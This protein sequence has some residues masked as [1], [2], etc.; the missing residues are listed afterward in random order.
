MNN[1]Y[2]SNIPIFGVSKFSNSD[3]LLTFSA[4]GLVILNRIFTYPERISAAIGKGWSE[5]T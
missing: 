1:A 2:E 4:V 5:L 3:V